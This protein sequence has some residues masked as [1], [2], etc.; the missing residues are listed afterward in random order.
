MPKLIVPTRSYGLMREMK[1]KNT[2]NDGLELQFP[3]AENILVW[4]RK[5]VREMAYDICEMPFTTYLAA[6][7]VGKKFTAL[8]L[9]ITRNFHH[10]AIHVNTESGLN[11]PK[12]M[13]GKTAG[14][15]RG[16][17]VTTGVWARYVLS[18]EYEVELNKVHWT[19]TDDEHVA[20]FNLPS[21]ADYASMGKS[22]EEM[23]ANDNIVA[24]VGTLPEPVKNVQPLIG[25]PQEA[26]FA[27][28]RRSGVYPVN[29]GIVVK[30]ELLEKYPGLAVDLFHALKSSKDKYL[31][32]INKEGNLTAED[33]LTV[34][35]ERGVGGDPFPYGIEP[36]RLA[37]EAL[38]Q[39]AYDQLITPRK[40][41]VEELFAEGTHDLVG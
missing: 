41:S 25:N 33:Q 2:I 23:F 8:P 29:H 7:S 17:T 37:L 27:S 22:F 6:K 10:Q 35:L 36:N 30:D 18:S 12:E 11:D 16:Y 26:G 14:I 40:F 34:E 21:F 38:T 4:A 19:C 3:E 32:S 13:E 5:M 28:Y 31:S 1:T 9:F 39:T 15:V 20:E 24:A